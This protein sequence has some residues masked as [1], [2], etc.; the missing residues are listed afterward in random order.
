M[1]KLLPLGLTTGSS[2]FFLDAVVK[3]RHDIGG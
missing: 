1:V 3:P 2:S